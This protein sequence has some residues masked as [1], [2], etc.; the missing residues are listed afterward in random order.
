[1][2]NLESPLLIEEV[3]SLDALRDEWTRLAELDG[4]LFKTWEWARAW[5][6]T[7]GAERRVLLTFA[8]DG[9]L[10][11]SAGSARRHC[12][13]SVSRVKGGPTR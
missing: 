11:D 5:E 7:Y 13:S 10:R 3:D 12:A 9:E 1:M 8:R 6:D 2:L 4:D